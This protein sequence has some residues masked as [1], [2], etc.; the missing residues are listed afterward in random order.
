MRKLAPSWEKK[1]ASEKEKVKF[2]KRPKLLFAL[3]SENIGHFATASIWMLAYSTMVFA[4]PIILN[5]FIAYMGDENAA[6][7][8]GYLYSSL[9][10]VINI[11]NAVCNSR[12]WFNALSIGLR[13]RTSLTTS[14]YKK[15][16]KLSVAGRKD[17]NSGEIVNLVNVDTTKIQRFPYIPLLCLG[18]PISNW[19]CYVSHLLTSWLVHICW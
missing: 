2:G 17:I 13:I 3:I 18:W 1:W 15:S 10:V 5:Y 9:L 7:W 4:S 14:I 6:D 19:A 16:L 8:K 11:T 12:Y